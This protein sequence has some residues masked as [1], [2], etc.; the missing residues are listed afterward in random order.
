MPTVS[1]RS[2]AFPVG[3]SVAI[4]PLAQQNL[5]PSGAGAAPIG[6]A[7]AIASAAVDAAGLLTVTNAGILQGVDYVAYA[8]VA[9]E[10]RYVRCR[11]TLDVGGTATDATATREARAIARKAAANVVGY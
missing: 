7:A 11:S 8:L 1:L 10:H 6:S 2:P 4:Y 5:T 9:G 3:Q